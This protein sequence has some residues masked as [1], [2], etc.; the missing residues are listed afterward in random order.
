MGGPLSGLKVIEFAG[1]G[2]C[3]HAAMILGDLGADVV[4]LE[5]PSGGLSLYPEGHHD[6]LLRNRRSVAV[7]LKK[8]DDRELAK[9]LVARCDVVIE[10]FRPGVAERLGVG[11]DDV[12][13]LNPRVVYGRVTG[14]GQEG[15][16]AARAGHDINYIALTGALHAIGRAEG[17][18]VPPLNLV[19]DFGGGS[20]HLVLGVLA[21]LW[22][23]E[24]SGRGQVVD[25]AMVD[26][27]SALM[28]MVWS[29]RGAD[30][31]ADR[32]GANLLDSGAPFYDTYECADGRYVAVGAL[33]PQFYAELLHG[34]GLGGSSIPDQLDPGRWTEL[35]E[36]FTRTFL[37][38]PRDHWAA[39]FAD[40]DACVTPVL[41][42]GE[43]ARHPHIAHRSTLVDVDGVLQAAPAPRF[44]RTQAEIP[45]PPRKPG[46][47][48]VDVL[49]DWLGARTE[50]A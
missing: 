29:L 21:A 44:S 16:L 4:R 17:N 36:L 50:G 32:R 26:G 18:P 3:P 13:A 14:W 20:L 10:G 23:R 33:E 49:D 27:T 37:T 24:R 15:P 38:Q 8:P 28:Q 34:L 41:A 19:G 40:T 42:L 11:P 9:R 47:D 1:L 12:L 25:A 7:D 45:L 46:E 22:E 39:L 43:V 2:P 30:S 35:R 5:R 48:T 31:W 6:Q